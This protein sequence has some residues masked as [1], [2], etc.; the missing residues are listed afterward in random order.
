MTLK[1]FVK[2]RRMMRSGLGLI[3]LGLV[4]TA[5]DGPSWFNPNV[6]SPPADTAPLSSP[7][8]DPGLAPPPPPAGAFLAQLSPAQTAQLKSL[9]VD[10]V[11]PGAVPPEFSVVDLRIDDSDLGLGYLIVYQDAAN[12]CFAVEFAAGNISDPLATESQ[13][14]IQPPL[15]AGQSYDLNYG[16]FEDGEM[17]LQF[18]GS[19]LYTDWLAGEFGFYRLIG[20]PY[21]GELFQPLQGCENI[22]PDEAVALVESFTVLT[23]DSIGDGPPPGQT[24]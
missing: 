11:V 1:T 2:P 17:R 7:G 23:A 16:E 10:V 21:I 14:P 15:F 22:T 6:G 24:P 3:L 4:A 19:N 20:A 8:A 18:P 12:R 9:G 13:V 5:C